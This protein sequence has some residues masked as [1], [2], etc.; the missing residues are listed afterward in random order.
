MHPADAQGR[1][2]V[3][4]L[5]NNT[6]MSGFQ[7]TF[8]DAES[9]DTIEIQ[10]MRTKDTLLEES[11]FTAY[12]NGG[13]IIA[14]SLEALTLSTSGRLLDI[15]VSYNKTRCKPLSLLG[16]TLI[17]CA[18]GEEWGT[19]APGSAGRNICCRNVYLADE[20]ADAIPVD[21]ACDDAQEENGQEVPTSAESPYPPPSMMQQVDADPMEEIGETDGAHSQT[22]S[23]LWSCLIVALCTLLQRAI[24][25][26]QIN[27]V[28][29]I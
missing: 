9:E 22:F 11:G 10:N 19:Q 1:F 7:M 29:I 4:L 16:S 24:G 3:D 15:T 23:L 26:M 2:S 13:M 27:I 5:L 18:C 20:N 25:A 14:L 28:D 6:T 17:V 8:Y 21:V 12:Y